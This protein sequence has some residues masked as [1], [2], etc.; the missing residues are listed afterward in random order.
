VDAD[1]V[2][3]LVIAQRDPGVANWLDAAGYERGTV[4][5]RYLFADDL[6]EVAYRAVPLGRLLDELPVGTERTDPGRRDRELRDRRAVLQRRL[7]R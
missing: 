1:G 6:P 7:G 5:V 2:A 3:R 4:A